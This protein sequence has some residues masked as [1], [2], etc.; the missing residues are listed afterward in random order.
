VCTPGRGA[1]VLT[2]RGRP[3]ALAPTP[4]VTPPCPV[5]CAHTALLP[6]WHEA[7]QNTWR[8]RGMACV[9]HAH[10]APRLSLAALPVTTTRMSWT[11][12]GRPLGPRSLSSCTRC[13]ALQLRAPKRDGGVNGALQRGGDTCALP[14]DSL[15][16]F[17]R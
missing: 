12:S 7:D 8:K 9:A 17:V 10:C 1:R 14:A 2:G 13:V 16:L 6:S 4:P 3:R 15:S 5:V 11:S